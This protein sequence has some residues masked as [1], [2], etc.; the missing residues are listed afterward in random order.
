[1]AT[2]STIRC[3]NCGTLNRVPSEARGV[4]HCG[5]CGTDLPWV[6]DVGPEDF[7]EAIDPA[8]PVLVD[9][10][11]DWC[12]PCRIVSPIV[13]GLARE[14]AGRLKVVKADVSEPSELSTRFN[15]QGI[16]LLVLMF[17]GQ[18]VDRLVGAVPAARL[19]AWLDGHLAAGGAGARAAG[20]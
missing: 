11:A 1:M 10:W 18:E 7:D 4:P 5:K 9:F 17:N 12:G 16:P 15:V 14:H 2:A 13:E 19:R 8:V 6:V 20:A 3:P